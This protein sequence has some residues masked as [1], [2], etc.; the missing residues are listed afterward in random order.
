MDIDVYGVPLDYGSGRRGVD[1]GPSAIRYAGLLQGLTQLKHTVRDCGNLEMPI[2]E[3]TPEGDPRLKH[4]NAVLPVV[5]RL[6]EQVG[7]TVAE[8]RVPLVLGGDHSLAIGSIAGASRHRRLGVLWLDAHGDFNTHETTPS[9]NIHGMPLAALCGLGDERLVTL[10]GAEPH[11]AKIHPHN[12]AVIG[13]RS[14]DEHEKVLL[15][16]AGVGVYSI[17]AIDRLGMAEVMHRAME[18]VS[19]D[20]DGI[21]VSLDL[22][23]V[24]PKFAPG[25]GTPVAGGMTFREAHLAVELVAESGRLVGMDVVECNTILDTMNQTAQLAVQLTLSAFGKRI[26]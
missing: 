4:L 3:N 26:W 11:G 24:D 15:R 2:T 10:G 19:R 17:D 13:A 25:V 22:D 12:V 5:Q 21:Y 1:M 9:G 6:A 8:G 16:E 23:A 7:K 20:T 18:N 14:L